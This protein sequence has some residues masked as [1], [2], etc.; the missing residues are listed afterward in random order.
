MHCV[1]QGNFKRESGLCLMTSCLTSLAVAAF[2]IVTHGEV[3]ILIVMHGERVIVPTD[4]FGP[5][6]L[7]SEICVMANL[8]EN[9]R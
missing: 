4:C 8:T 5:K 6:F 7:F 2:L 3:T 1:S 9:K